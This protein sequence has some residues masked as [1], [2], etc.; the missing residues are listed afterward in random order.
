M[1]TIREDIIELLLQKELDAREISGQ[2]GVSEKDVTEHLNH[3][4]RSLA[5]RGLKLIITPAQCYACGYTFKDRSR[6][7]KPGK[8]PKCRSEH[9]DPPRFSIK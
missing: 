9:I 4:S 1:G 3:I 2:V 6:P 5:N 8:C 7:K